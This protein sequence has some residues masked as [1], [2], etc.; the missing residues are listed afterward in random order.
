[1][2]KVNFSRNFCVIFDLNIS[3]YI[4]FNILKLISIVFNSTQLTS[5]V[6]RFRLRSTFEWNFMH[7]K[8][9]RRFSIPMLNIN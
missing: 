7:L 2:Y 3:F 1:M 8:A 5:F 9:L 4:Y 6:E